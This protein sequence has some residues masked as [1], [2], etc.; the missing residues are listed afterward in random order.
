MTQRPTDPTPTPAWSGDDDDD[1][2]KKDGGR[3]LRLDTLR[4]SLGE[5]T[6]FVVPTDQQPF[7]L[8]NLPSDGNVSRVPQAAPPAAPS[9][10]ASGV[11]GAA[12]ERE[13]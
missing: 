4:K 6:T 12:G 3:N 13:E 7:H 1:N 5:N 11:T 8:L 9:A 10:P 2:D